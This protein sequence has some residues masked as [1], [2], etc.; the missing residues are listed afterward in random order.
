MEIWIE[1]PLLASGDGT[2]CGARTSPF[3]IGANGIEVE[4]SRVVVG[5]TEAGSIVAIPIEDGAAGTPT[6]LAT[7]LCGI[8]GLVGDDGVYFASV[9]GRQ[10]VRVDG[11]TVSVVH[12]GLPLRTPAGIDVGTFGGS[13]QAIVS[14]PDFEHAFGEG[15]PASAMPSLVAISL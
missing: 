4:A 13:R 8:D 6:T 7:E 12:E 2:V 15:G 9:L 10:V 11:G 1:D 14:N 5:N 3:P